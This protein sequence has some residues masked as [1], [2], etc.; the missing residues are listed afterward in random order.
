MAPGRV[1]NTTSTRMGSRANLPRFGCLAESIGSP[2]SDMPAE[3]GLLQRVCNVGR[4]ATSQ[5]SCYRPSCKHYIRRS[6]G[7]LR[8]T[9]PLAG[10][11]IVCEERL[12]SYRYLEE[13]PFCGALGPIPWRYRP[14]PLVRRRG[15]NEPACP[16]AL[17]FG[18]SRTF[19]KGTSA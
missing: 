8:H 5:A 10:I 9:R 13:R 18:A 19:C 16:K 17:S 6:T 15:R 3:T 14:L 1:P 2:A 12:R 11:Q 7:Q 4:L